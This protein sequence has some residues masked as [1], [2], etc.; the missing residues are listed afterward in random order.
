MP[1]NPLI[2]KCMVS[3][4]LAALYYAEHVQYY[5]TLIDKTAQFG[6]TVHLHKLIEI[7]EGEHAHVL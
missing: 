6:R 3:W 2:T 7:L 1:P 5:H 4:F